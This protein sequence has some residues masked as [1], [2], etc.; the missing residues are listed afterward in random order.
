MD[1]TLPKLEGSLIIK[2][3]ESAIS[4]IKSTSAA[5]CLFLV[6]I[7]FI[8]IIFLDT[9]IKHR[10]QTSHLNYVRFHYGDTVET[11]ARTYANL[12]KFHSERFQRTDIGMS[13]KATNVFLIGAGETTE[14]YLCHD[15]EFADDDILQSLLPQGV[16]PFVF[17]TITDALHALDLCCTSEQKLPRTLFILLLISTR[18]PSLERHEHEAFQMPASLRDHC[19]AIV[20]TGRGGNGVPAHKLSKGSKGPDGECLIMDLRAIAGVCFD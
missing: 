4:V 13:V 8:T 14:A 1:H 3:T 20:G 7:F 18:D 9:L 11:T 12:I 19:Y 15:R 6:A 17:R 10:T 16:Q 2:Q 5:L